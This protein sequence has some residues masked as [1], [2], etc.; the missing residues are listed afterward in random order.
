MDV[1]RRMAESCLADHR[2]AGRAV[3]QHLTSH[4]SRFR[5]TSAEK[6]RQE[7]RIEPYP[8][9]TPKQTALVVAALHDVCCYNSEKVI[10]IEKVIEK[11]MAGMV[12]DFGTLPD[13]PPV[14]PRPVAVRDCGRWWSSLLIQVARLP[15]SSAPWFRIQVRELKTVIQAEIRRPP[16]GRRGRKQ[17][18]DPKEDKRIYDGWKNSGFR[19]YK[20]YA[21]KCGRTERDIEKALDRH[22]KR[23]KRTRVK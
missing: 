14:L 11:K 8:D 17:K 12:P 4:S 22:E 18:S 10:E 19:S 16:P 21:E 15:E 9:L 6:N 5:S 1:I 20:A 2:N 3:I 7:V 23:L 13:D